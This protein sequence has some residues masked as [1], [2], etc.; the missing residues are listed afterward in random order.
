[1]NPIPTPSREIVLCPLRTHG[2]QHFVPQLRR[3]IIPR[4]VG[5]KEGPKCLSF[6]SETPAF[7]AVDQ[8]LLDREPLVD[9]EL[10]IE[11][12]I[13]QII[14]VFTIHFVPPYRESQ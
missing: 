10:L 7:P 13:Q 1:M 2:C 14:D 5:S 9:F 4:R 8:M 12:G 11:I 3:R 6:L